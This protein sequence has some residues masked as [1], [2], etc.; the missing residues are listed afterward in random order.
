MRAYAT[1]IL[2]GIRSSALGIYVMKVTFAA[3]S[4]LDLSSPVQTTTDGIAAHCSWP[5]RLFGRVKR[6][7]Y[8]A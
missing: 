1:W 6:D 3:A 5:S 8:V 2:I 7:A 4:A